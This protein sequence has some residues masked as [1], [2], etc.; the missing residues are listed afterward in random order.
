MRRRNLSAP[1][2]RKERESETETKVEGGL[3]QTSCPNSEACYE[4]ETFRQTT[5]TPLKATMFQIRRTGWTDRLSGVF[6]SI[7]T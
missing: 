2:E 7:E 3:F 1:S 5:H 4:C 6:S